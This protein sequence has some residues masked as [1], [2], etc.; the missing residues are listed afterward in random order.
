MTVSCCRQL[1]LILQLNLPHPMNLRRSYLNRLHPQN[2]IQHLSILVLESLPGLI[3][4]QYQL[5]LL[6]LVTVS[7]CRQLDL[8]L[9]SNLPHPMNLRRSYLNCLHPQNL[10][11][12]LSI[13]VL[14][15]LPG[16]IQNQYQLLLLSL[17]TVSCCRQLDLIL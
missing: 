12:H 1:D 17:V 3:Q 15:S 5:L 7:C 14:E 4:N 8:I 2:L 10:I 13:L 6:L 11:Q 16:L 9:Q